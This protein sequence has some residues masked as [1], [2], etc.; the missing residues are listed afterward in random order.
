MRMSQACAS[1]LQTHVPKIALQVKSEAAEWALL[2][3]QWA[4][5]AVTELIS[6]VGSKGVA[7]R[8]CMLCCTV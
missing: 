4:P 2:L 6:I 5:A 8:L 7:L 3:C 1:L